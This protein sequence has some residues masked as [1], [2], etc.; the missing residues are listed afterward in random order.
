MLQFVQIVIGGLLQGC[1]F[2]LLAIGFS[3]IYR[4]AAAVNLAQGAF[5]IIGALVTATCETSLG[6]PVALACLIGV[7]AT[8]VLATALGLRIPPQ[9]LWMIGVAGVIAGALAFLLMRTKI[10]RAFR[11]CAENPLAANL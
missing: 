7:A 1:I 3:L 4:V 5:C 8:G 6:L 10:G 2:G 11:A 9:G